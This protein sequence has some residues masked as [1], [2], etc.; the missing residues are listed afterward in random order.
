MN[1]NTA[2]LLL[3]RHSHCGAESRPRVITS[4][5][6]FRP[7]NAPTGTHERLLFSSIFLQYIKYTVKYFNFGTN[8]KDEEDKSMQM[9]AL[10]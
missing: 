6:L 5:P 2:L 1:T 10:Q 9:E 8:F 3:H 7:L 4:P